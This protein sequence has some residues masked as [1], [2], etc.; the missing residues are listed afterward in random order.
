M[1]EMI[2]DIGSKSGIESSRSGFWTHHAGEVSRPLM[3]KQT[4]MPIDRGAK[5]LALKTK[6]L[7]TDKATKP[8][9]NKRREYELQGK[10]GC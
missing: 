9:D 3:Q 6:K 7:K 8:F 2:P 5:L 4:E 10:G 1:Q